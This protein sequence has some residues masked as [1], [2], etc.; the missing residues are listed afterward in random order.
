MGP[1]SQRASCH[2]CLGGEQNLVAT[3]E[4]LIL[5]RIDIPFREPRKEWI[6]ALD[7]PVLAS[8]SRDALAISGRKGIDM[9]LSTLRFS[10]KLPVEPARLYGAWLDGKEHAAFTGGPARID[11]RVGGTFTAWG[12]YIRGTTLELEDGRRIVQS[13][14]ASE[15]AEGDADS[16]IC[17]VFEPDGKSGTLLTLEHFEV[18]VAIAGLYEQGWMEYYFKPM[19]KYF[20]LLRDKEVAKAKSAA[21]QAAFKKAATKKAPAKKAPAKKAPAKKAP[22]KKAP[23]KK[24]PA[25]KA[26]AKKR[27]TRDAS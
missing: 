5:R 7:R 21:R 9:E 6:A 1:G 19:R 25:K 2:G 24:A 23:T 12:D 13:W 3:T 22:T 4:S 18:P 17:L 16:K 11:P 20:R 27:S 26:P 15:F 10:I 14:R 8:A